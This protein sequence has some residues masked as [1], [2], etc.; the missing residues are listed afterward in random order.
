[1]PA[2]VLGAHVVVE[3]QP[4]A[5]TSPAHLGLNPGQLCVLVI[6][7]ADAARAAPHGIE[8]DGDVLCQGQ[9]RQQRHLRPRPVPQRHLG[10]EA[11]RG[12]GGA[13]GRLQPGHQQVAGIWGGVHSEGVGVW[14][15]GGG[16]GVKGGRKRDRGTA[17]TGARGRGSCRPQQL[18][19]C[20][21]CLRVSVGT[22][23]T[24]L[25]HPQQLLAPGQL[26]GQPGYQHTAAVCPHARTPRQLTLCTCG[27]DQWW[28][29]RR[30]AV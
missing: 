26:P 3:L 17:S 5:G 25:Y 21:M 24:C 8:G 29:R 2:P 13:E 7:P 16:G 10:R 20:V 4:Q 30:L 15:W 1:V 9:V 19:R 23:A 11:P 6:P 12:Q 22:G 28:W 18:W 27:A 14:V